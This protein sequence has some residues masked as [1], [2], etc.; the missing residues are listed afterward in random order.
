MDRVGV[1][2]RREQEALFFTVIVRRDQAEHAAQSLSKDGSAR[3]TVEVVAEEPSGGLRPADAPA[4]RPAHDH[5]APT[6]NC[7]T[8][9]VMRP[10]KMQECAS[11]P[12][13]R[14][15]SGMIVL[16]LLDTGERI[17]TR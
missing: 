5:V 14:M 1:S 10:A 13:G 17:T 8:Y 15:A 16:M 11:T 4:R 3:S 7:T 9:G 6:Y 2:G 12:R